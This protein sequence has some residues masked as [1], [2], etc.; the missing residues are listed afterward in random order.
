MGNAVYDTTH[1]YCC[2]V[3][4][5]H[6]FDDAPILHIMFSKKIVPEIY[7]EYTLRIGPK[8]FP[9]PIS[10]LLNEYIGLR[11]RLCTSAQLMV[12]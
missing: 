9:L 2:Y 11:P 7:A 4:A 12:R 8:P 5:T 1:S 10:T 3:D 6:M